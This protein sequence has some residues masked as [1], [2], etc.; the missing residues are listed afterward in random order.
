MANL[1]QK[2]WFRIST[3]SS[4]FT[5]M[6]LVSLVLTYPSAALVAEIEAGIAK[7]APDI[8]NLMIEDAAISGLG[9]RLSNVEFTYGK[10]E[11]P[12][13]FD[14]LH[15][16]LAGF[17]FDPES[18]AF[19]LSAVAYGGELDVQVNGAVVEGQVD[20]LDLSAVLP[21]QDMLGLGIGG[22]L[23]GRLEMDVTDPK[24]KWRKANGAVNL[25]LSAASIGPGKLPIPGFGQPLT[26][27]EIRVGDIPLGLEVKEGKA[28]LQPIKVT[29]EQLELAAKGEVTLQRSLRLS[30][31]DLSVD[32]RPTKKLNATQE[33]KNLLNVLDRKSPLLPRRVKRNMSKKGWLG[34]SVSGRMSRP[35]FRMRKSNIR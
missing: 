27:P 18:P 28:S 6:F 22:R 21:L 7:G 12:W 2:R 1:W 20:A 11:I 30:A 19:S 9:L 29:G 8:K 35:R 33:G 13:R 5:T 23:S 34:M 3:Y 26:V 10:G 15:I 24:Q 16:G 31:L 14:D 32:A 25:T 4:F 17:G